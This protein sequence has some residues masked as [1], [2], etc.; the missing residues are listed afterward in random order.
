M[1]V[2]DAINTFRVI[3]GVFACFCVLKSSVS[4][5]D[6]R[7]RNGFDSRQALTKGNPSAW[8]NQGSNVEKG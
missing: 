8:A 3:P 7:F 6:L 4:E 2:V 5:G 1:V